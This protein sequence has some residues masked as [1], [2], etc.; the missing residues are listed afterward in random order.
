MKYTT[1]ALAGSAREV[2]K[3][4]HP[5]SHP[6]F[7]LCGLRALRVSALVRNYGSVKSIRSEAKDI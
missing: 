6:P 3:E 7:P 4:K 1:L 2:T 5:K